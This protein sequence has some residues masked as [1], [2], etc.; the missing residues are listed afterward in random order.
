MEQSRLA[1]FAKLQHEAAHGAWAQRIISELGYLLELS[2][3]QDCRLDER[4]LPQVERLLEIHAREG[5]IRRDDALAVEQA[6]ADLRPA[7]KTYEVTCAAHAHI[8]MNWMWGF[9]ETAALTVDTF[10]TMLELMERYPDFTFSQSQASVYHILETYH[11]AMLEEIRRRVREGRWEVTASSWVE[12]DKNL[13]GGEAMARHLLYTR[14]Y[15]SELLDIPQEQIQL[16]FEPDTFGHCE[17]LPEILHQ[18]GIRYYYHCRGAEGPYLYRW[19]A[20]S[21]AEVLAYREPAWYNQTIDGSLFL[22]V[23]SFCSRYGI[24]RYLKVYG[25]GDH[26]GGPTRRDIDRLMDMATWPLFPTIVFGTIQ[27]F[28]QKLEADGLSV[29]TVTGELNYVFTGCYS[30]QSRIKRANRLSEERLTQAELLDVMA[31]S[32]CPRYRTPSPF[33][34]AWR[35]VLFNQFHDIL[36]GSGVVDTREYAMGEYQKALTTASINGNQA[37]RSFAAQ[38]DTAAFFPT[39]EAPLL[40]AAGVG[41][42]TSEPSGFGFSAS[43]Q[44][45]GENRVF[46]LFNTAQFDRR[47]VAELT[48]WDW[49]GDPTRLRCFDAQGHPLPAQVLE[50]GTHYWGHHFHRVAVLAQAPGFGY[51][52]LGLCCCAPEQV[53][54]PA[55]PEPRVD[56]V[57]D[58]PVVLENSRLRAAFR[59]GTLE[60]LSLIEKQSGAEL[61]DPARPSGLFQLVTEETS[62][63]MTAWRVGRHTAVQ[64]LNTQ[65]AVTIRAVTSGPVRQELSFEIPWGNSSLRGTIRLDAE[66]P[67]LRYDLQVD[68]REFGSPAGIPQLRFALPLAGPLPTS[69]CRTPMG[70][71][72]RP[73]LAQDVPCLG[74]LAAETASGHSVALLS[75]CKYGFRNDGAALGLTLLRSSYDP[76]PTPEIGTHTMSLAV[77]VGAEEELLSLE[78]RYALPWIS[79]SNGL[80][81][82]SLPPQ[83]QFLQ[84]DGCQVSAVKT[85]EDGS[86]LILRLYNPTK[87]HQ[88]ALLRFSV[89]VVSAL[90]QTTMETPLPIPCRWAEQTVLTRLEAFETA[91][92]RVVL[93]SGEGPEAG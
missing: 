13:S 56:Q 42:G 38:V 48:L 87:D 62:A 25:V 46:T 77:A 35:Q 52:T 79:V 84:A 92:V 1:H 76:D 12:N 75:D 14:Q 58:A 3:T 88:T 31:H 32:A 50:S 74:M 89:P 69:L 49:P 27:G 55:F 19:R 44:L 36:P 41:F 4:L 70:L 9:Q 39:E 30:S 57:T 81:R 24:R 2:R 29:E 7:A 65:A 47:D 53:D 45:G 78:R 15:L 5:A 83:G 20:P 85:A 68:W 72:R 18:G 8:D 63:G 26:G 80:Q 90:R 23:P 91:T 61:V 34:P 16:D 54:M 33:A 43:A 64:C 11:P 67:V 86:G 17:N 71:T 28:F 10:R 93:S 73:A 21:G 51:T 59:P 6:L 40:A 66:S 22:T 82:G 60:L 37:M